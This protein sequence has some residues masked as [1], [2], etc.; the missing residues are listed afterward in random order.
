MKQQGIYGLVLAGGKSTR[1][2]V[3]KSLLFYHGKTQVE[4]AFELLGLYCAKVFVSN[5]QDQKQSQGHEH[6]PQLHDLPEYSG[7]GP[8]GGILSALTK[9]PNAA[10]LVMACDLPFVTSETIEYLIGQRDPKKNATAFIS[11]HDQLPEP[12]CAIWETH[13]QQ[14]ILDFFKQG[15]QC[16]RK[17]LIKSDV[18]LIEQQDKRWLDNVNNPQEYKDALRV[19]GNKPIDS[20]GKI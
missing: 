20:K 16:P 12:L 7:I 5:R 13:T 1:M 18:H 19:L 4:H 2:N 17:I 10:W 14:I 6:L 11:V 9:F 3:D 8:I 15:I